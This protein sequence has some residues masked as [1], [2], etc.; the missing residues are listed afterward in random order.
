MYGNANKSDL[1]MD[2]WGQ[3][4][5]RPPPPREQQ[6]LQRM[7]SG[8]SNTPPSW[9]MTDIVPEETKMTPPRPQESHTEVSLQPSEYKMKL[10]GASAVAVWT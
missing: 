10:L 7:D 8:K 1:G 5:P 2:N 9:S 6:S 4:P 3:L